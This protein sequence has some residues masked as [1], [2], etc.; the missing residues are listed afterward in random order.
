MRPT[1][2]PRAARKPVRLSNRSS[3][4]VEAE[5]GVG[6]ERAQLDRGLVGIAGD[7]E[8][9]LD[10]R[11]RL[12]RQRGRRAER[13]LFEEAL[14]DLADRAAADRGDAG[15]RQQVGDQRVRGLRVGAGQRRQHALVFRPLARRRSA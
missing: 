15:D 11:A 13:R 3:A 9:A 8:E 14:G 5:L 1:S 4:G 10:Q 12:A 2:T 7:A 6:G